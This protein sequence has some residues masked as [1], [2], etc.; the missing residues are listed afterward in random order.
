MM[1]IIPDPLGRSAPDIPI[2]DQLRRHQ[3]KIMQPL[4]MVCNAQASPAPSFQ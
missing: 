4:A 1:I 3:V 2:F